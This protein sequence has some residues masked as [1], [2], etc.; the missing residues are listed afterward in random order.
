MTSPGKTP[1][2]P[3]ARRKILSVL[4]AGVLMG[5]LDIAIVGPALPA[6]QADFGI[7]GR[8]L[9]LAFGV[10]LLASLL[11]APLMSKL[12]DRLGRR[13]IYVS[14]IALFALG[15][16]FVA[17]APTYS[18]FL[19][20]RA[21]QGLG[22]GGIFPVASA[23]IGDTFPVERCGGA[24]GLIGAVFGLAF[25]IGPAVAGVILGFFG[26]RWLFIVNLPIA[27]AVAFFAWRTLP[28]RTPNVKRPFDWTGMVLL[29]AWLITLNRLIGTEREWSSPASWLLVALAVAIPPAFI[30]AERRAS[31][32]VLRVGLFARKQIQIVAFLALVTGISEAALV[33]VPTLL[34][35]AF[36]VTASRA[37]YMLLPIVFAM[38]LGSPLAGKAL[39]RFG[40]RV[41]VLVG[42]ALLALGFVSVSAVEGSIARFYIAGGIVG[43][44]LS[45]LLGAP[46]RYIVLGE[47]PAEERAA[48]Q[49]AL[50]LTTNVGI[51]IGSALI[52]AL[53]FTRGGGLDGYE[54]AFQ[55]IG[56]LALVGFVAAFGLKRRAAERSATNDVSLTGSS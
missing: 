1:V 50:T 23:V 33:F 26:W 47:A 17:T 37:S 32:P 18:L 54:F 48:A 13:A 41:V 30:V 42:A 34:V 10:Y 8:D 20:G 15:S 27:A 55:V 2:D 38:A 11:G 43:L 40:S 21:V 51:L 53:A 9:G 49:G 44:G 3:I 39:D 4:F 45:M 12:S 25:L 5:A 22:A 46:L 35:E 56:G 16:L 52:G 31:D 14:N 28:S 19:A 7:R 29:L 24:L 6:L 36:G